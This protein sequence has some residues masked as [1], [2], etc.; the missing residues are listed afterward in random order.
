[1]IQEL[2]A[3]GWHNSEKPNRGA[4]PTS[5]DFPQAIHATKIENNVPDKGVGS[6][7]APNTKI[8]RAM[9]RKKTRNVK[10]WSNF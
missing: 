1:M 8:V 4:S 6:M 2:A 7:H 9:R 5:F 10:I 3:L